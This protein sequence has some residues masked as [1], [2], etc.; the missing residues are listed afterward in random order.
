MFR[1]HGFRCSRKGRRRKRPGSRFRR[2]QK[3]EPQG[4]KGQEGRGSFASG[5]ASRG[6]PI[7]RGIKPSKSRSSRSL[8]QGVKTAGEDRDSVTG[9]GSLEGKK[10]WRLKAQGCG[11]G[12]TNPTGRDGGPWGR[13]AGSV[14]TLWVGSGGSW[15][16][17]RSGRIYFVHRRARKLM[18]AARMGTSRFAAGGTEGRESLGRSPEGGGKVRERSRFI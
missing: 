13:L 3:G 7:S 14:E 12:E 10:P 15:Q 4:R 2:S 8:L 1:N 18:G 11:R 16:P 5:N 17:R 6:I 9:P